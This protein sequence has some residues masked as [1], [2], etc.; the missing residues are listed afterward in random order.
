MLFSITSCHTKVKQISLNLSISYIHFDFANSANTKT[1]LNN[2][3]FNT[4]N[5]LTTS[6]YMPIRIERYDSVSYL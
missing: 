1:E 5:E 3:K 2:N 6:Y 4:Q